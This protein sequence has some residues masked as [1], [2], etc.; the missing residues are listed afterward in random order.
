MVKQHKDILRVWDEVSADHPKKSTEWQMA[1][2]IDQYR[3]RHRGDID[4]SD[5]V[6]ALEAR[7]SER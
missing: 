4:T 2:T 5:I 7:L 6:D 3:D 1:M